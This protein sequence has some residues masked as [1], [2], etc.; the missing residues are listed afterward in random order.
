MMTAAPA[1]ICLKSNMTL[2]AVSR[3]VRDGTGDAVRPLKIR[4]GTLSK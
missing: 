2:L 4:S 3:G 1:E